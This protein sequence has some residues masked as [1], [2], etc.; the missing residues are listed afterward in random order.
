[1][2]P[3][4][5]SPGSAAR[6]CGRSPALSFLLYLELFHSCLLTL[7]C[8]ENRR[9]DRENTMSDIK[10]LGRVG[11]CAKYYLGTLFHFVTS[12]TLETQGIISRLAGKEMEF[13]GVK[14]RFLSFLGV[15]AC[16][17]L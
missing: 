2:A 11:H 12:A 15:S 1:M 5:A 9:K 7:P 8:K 4:R 3:G 16:G 6:G 13:L 10:F 17:C 14:M